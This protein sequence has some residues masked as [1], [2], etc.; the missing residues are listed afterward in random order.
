ME[1]KNV[2]GEVIFALEAAK[3]VLELVTAAV[4]ARADL[5]GAEL[6]GADLSGAELRGADLSGAYLSGADLR[7]ADLSEADLSEADL[8][9][10]EL[11]GADLSGADL[12]GAYLSGAYLSGA[13]LSGAD[14]SGKKIT[15][16][17]VFSGLYDYQVWAVLLEDGSRWVRMG[18][19]WKSLEDWETVGIRE[20]NELE[21]PDDG[22]DKC[23]ERVAAFEF[24]KAAALRMK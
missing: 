2:F 15:S 8:S 20:S 14:L 21:F 11:R 7:G 1:L 10:A 17:R 19:L 9:G 3:T 12:S 6:C 23:E 4:A 22:S 18:C 5:S 16:M 24:A 13:D